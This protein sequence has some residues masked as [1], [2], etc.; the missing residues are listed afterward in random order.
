MNLPKELTTVTPL[1]KILAII[2][3]ITFPLMGFYLGLSYQKNIEQAQVTNNSVQNEKSINLQQAG[4]ADNQVALVGGDHSL[5][6]LKFPDDSGITTDGKKFISRDSE[7][8][9]INNLLA[10]YPPVKIY[11]LIGL[12]GET[13]E[14]MRREGEQNSG[15]NLP[16]MRT[17]FR[18]QYGQNYD[19][20]GV[21]EQLKNYSL[22]EDINFAPQAVPLPNLSNQLF[23]YRGEVD[24]S[25][26]S[27][28]VVSAFRVS[29]N[30][31]LLKD[32]TVKKVIFNLPDGVSYTVVKERIFGCGAG[33][34]TDPATCPAGCA[35]IEY[36]WIGNIE[37]AQNDAPEKVTI[38]VNGNTI[39]GSIPEV[40]GVNK[41]QYRIGNMAEETSNILFKIDPSK[42]GVD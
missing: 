13:L 25:K 2:F 33:E 16:D 11:N 17:W 34:C 9:Q 41:Y 30:T 3:F 23:N 37:E 22:V 4:N 36:T 15:N 27:P 10:S 19:A 6:E 26:Y 29:V 42:Y 35:T 1:S 28:T 5:I 20:T 14:K 24:G 31:N 32:K 39:A 12:P 40:L 18:I 21:M 38:V 8:A 7:I